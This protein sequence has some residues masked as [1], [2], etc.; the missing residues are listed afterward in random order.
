MHS[1]CFSKKCV[2]GICTGLSNGEQCHT[3]ADCNAESFC[4]QDNSWPY[5][6]KCDKSKTNYEQCNEDY[7]CGISAY[8]W[9]VSISDR[10]ANVKKCLP[11]YSQD[12]G[13]SLGWLS[14]SNS[15]FTYAEYE[16]NGRYCKSGLAFPVTNVTSSKDG[17]II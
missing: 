10:E 2:S 1:Q 4:K 12:V 5:V 6:S 3:H 14:A 16:L 17:K 7:E 15:N 8:C 11:L 13:T 9:Y